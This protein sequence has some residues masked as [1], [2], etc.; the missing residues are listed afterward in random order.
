MKLTNRNLIIFFVC[1]VLLAAGAWGILR[2]THSGGG[3]VVVTVDGEPYGT[4]SLF[5]P[6]EVTIAPEDGAWYNILQ[7]ANGQ[8]EIIESDCHN[9]ICV[10]TP[11]LTG[12]TVGVIA[13]LPHGVVVEVK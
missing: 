6:R 11:P 10:L 7:I 4:Y 1:I 3:Q 2:I 8:A 5:L 13:C 9:Q 12:D